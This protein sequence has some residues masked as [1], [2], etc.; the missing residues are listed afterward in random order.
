MCPKMNVASCSKCTSFTVEYTNDYI[1][2]CKKCF[3]N[4]CFD[5]VL[6]GDFPE[7]ATMGEFRDSINCM[8]IPT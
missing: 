8:K 3:L 1:D 2:Y 5:G 7:S 4:I 6:R